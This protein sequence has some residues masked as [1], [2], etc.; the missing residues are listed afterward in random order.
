MKRCNLCKKEII[1][2]KNRAKFCDRICYLEHHKHI[3][4]KAICC[5][6]KT[7]FDDRTFKQKFCSRKCARI[8]SKGK[9]KS[10][11]R[12]RID[13]VGYV[14]IPT[15]HGSVR[16]HVFVWEAY[17]NKKVPDGWVIHHK[18]HDR[19]DNRIENLEAMP[20]GDH[21]RLHKLPKG[22]CKFCNKPQN[23]RKLCPKHYSAWRRQSYKGCKL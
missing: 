9:L 15:G 16:F 13:S 19:L 1:K 5:F 21:Q 14:T 3:Y 12:K 18:N 20:R 22:R 23:A 4:N 17:N 10:H 7:E 11:G 8:F 2:R 6:C